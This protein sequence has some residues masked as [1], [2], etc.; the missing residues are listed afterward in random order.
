MAKAKSKSGQD[1]GVTG[2]EDLWNVWYSELHNHATGLTVKVN[3]LVE[4]TQS[5]FQ[6]ID[7]IDN[8]LRK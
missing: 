2:M 8:L 7:V 5:K 4:S 6:R 3:R 1:V